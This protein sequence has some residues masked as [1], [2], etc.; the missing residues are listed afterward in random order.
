[1]EQTRKL[2]MLVDDSRTNL[3]TGKSALADTYSV[4]AMPSAAKMLEML[5]R[6]TP[7]MILLDVDMP[8]MNGY[9]AIRVIKSRP[10]TKDIPVIFLTA[11]SSASNELE[12]LELGAI[13]YIT[14]PFS[15]VLLK[16]RVEVH[17]LV[18]A[19]KKALRDYNENLQSMVEEKTRTVVKLQNKIMKAVSDLVEGRDDSTGGHI[20]RTQHYLKILLESLLEA[21]LYSDQIDNDW[22]IDL[23]LSS[24]LLHDVGKIVISDSILKKPGK[25]TADEFDQIKQHVDFGVRFIENL[26]EDEDDRGFLKYAKIFAGYHHER[27]DGSGYPNNLR[28]MEI[29]LM[30]RLMAIADVYDALTSVRPYKPAFDH[31]DAVEI[32]LAG[33]GTHFDPVLVDLFEKIHPLFALPIEENEV[34]EGKVS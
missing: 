26:E 32:I 30:G 24:S 21:G 20:E 28:G 15:P 1:M 14:K 12:G 33:R 2:I 16:K 5:E 25:L 11:M 7:E 13:D 31:Q 6:H 27:W 34:A 17:L 18:A 3:L 22:D 9:E 10:E 29:P 23:L 19:Q 4:L 8:E